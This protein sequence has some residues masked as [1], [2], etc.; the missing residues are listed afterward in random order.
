MTMLRVLLIVTVVI[1]AYLVVIRPREIRRWGR[2][3]R[4]IAFIY[5]ATILISAVLQAL[6]LYPGL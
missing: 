2:T 3:A 4:K 6:G 5:I 1:V